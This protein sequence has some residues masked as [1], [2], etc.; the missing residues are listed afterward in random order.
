[1]EFDSTRWA[2][3]LIAG[4]IGLAAFFLIGS[5]SKKLLVLIAAL[6]FLEGVLLSWRSFYFVGFSLSS[7][8]SYVLLLTIMLM[9]DAR[10]RLLAFNGAWVAFLFF[11]LM[12]V[13]IGSFVSEVGV[14]ANLVLF[15]MF[16]LEGLFYFWIGRCALRDSVETH[17][18][19]TWL[20]LF[21][22]VVSLLHLF[23]ITTG[24]RFY[25]AAGKEFNEYSNIAYRYGAVFSN[26]NTLAD[27][28]SMAIPVGLVLCLG[29]VRPTRRAMAGIVG[30]L[31]LMGVS[32]LLTA[33]RGGLAATVLVS[34]V[35]VLL[36]PIGLRRVLNLT[37]VSIIA[38]TFAMALLFLVFP[39]FLEKSLARFTDMGLQSERYR[40]WMMTLR[41]LVTN[42]VGIGL[43]SSGYIQAMRQFG[44]DLA[45]PHN[46]YLSL[47]VNI[48]I[49]GLIAYLVIVVG[50]LRRIL[51]ARRFG[52]EMLRTAATAILVLLAGFLLS[53]FFEP[54][55]RN[56]FKLQHLF[57]LFAGVG[58]FL[59]NWIESS[60][61]T[62]FDTDRPHWLDEERDIGGGPSWQPERI[63][64][65]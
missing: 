23:S 18:I 45:N 44:I 37:V 46:I 48:G 24:Y 17:K 59:P 35:A 34:A 6:I 53:G 38:G 55:Y 25:A 30:S 52:D 21:G 56:G 36:L 65:L 49:P 61:P 63:G 54:I 15:Q 33:S 58:S 64:S 43:H 1:M 3:Y 2:V 16:Y 57:W 7:A 22:G 29:W 41:L 60:V 4:P 27:F 9:P 13:L 19:L 26:P 14:G 11:A 32:L 51:L 12:G 47:A 20:V 50:C 5:L 10:S 8:V 42:P 40:T 28:Y 39:E 62:E 31:S